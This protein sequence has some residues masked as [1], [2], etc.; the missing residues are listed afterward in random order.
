MRNVIFR[1]FANSIFNLLGP[2]SVVMTLEMH[3]PCVTISIYSLGILMILNLLLIVLTL[4]L[5]I[6]YS[7]DVWRFYEAIK[8]KGLALLTKF[9]K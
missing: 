6:N 7:G 9:N 5:L 8:H 1:I 3:I 2:V 4:I